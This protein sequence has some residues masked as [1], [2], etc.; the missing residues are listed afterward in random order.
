MK[1]EERELRNTEML[2]FNVFIQTEHASG[3]HVFVATRLDDDGNFRDALA[4]DHWTGTSG[5]QERLE[6]KIAFYLANS[7]SSC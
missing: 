4:V 7:E 1:G 3:S 2:D 6:D 5:I